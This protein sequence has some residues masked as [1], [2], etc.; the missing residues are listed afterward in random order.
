MFAFIDIYF[1]ETQIRAT[2]PLPVVLF[3]T[4]RYCYPSFTSLVLHPNQQSRMTM[5][6]EDV[7]GVCME[8]LVLDAKT[9][10]EFAKVCSK[11]H[12]A[13]LNHEPLWME[14]M[15]LR[16]RRTSKVRMTSGMYRARVLAD[17]S[18]SPLRPKELAEIENCAAKF[19]N[20]CPIYAE[21]LRAT[22]DVSPL[23]A[24]VLFCSVC[25]DKVYCA[26]TQEEL[27]Y[28]RYQGRCV[29]FHRQVLLSSD[30]EPQTRANNIVNVLVVC[31]DGDEEGRSTR[32]LFAHAIKCAPHGNMTLAQ[33]SAS[34]V[35][36]MEVK[37][38]SFPSTTM[39][40][41][42]ATLEQAKTKFSA[43]NSCDAIIIPT[44]MDPQRVDAALPHLIRDNVIRLTAIDY[45]DEKGV[46]E[47]VKRLFLEYGD[48]YAM[49]FI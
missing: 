14:L 31:P 8:F 10:H 11:W 34:F 25:Q 6:P 20:E 26:L 36:K 42:E 1:V 49:G 4:H 23:G 47:L 5:L 35:P 22:G 32:H 2:L 15:R 39:M 9:L 13:F 37:Y 41:H 45:S 19:Q 12:S 44:D 48:D 17:R 21:A 7:V 38:S 16:W 29:R 18:F 24:P 3:S 43:S 33:F 28:H 40:Y 30:G 27:Q 46:Q